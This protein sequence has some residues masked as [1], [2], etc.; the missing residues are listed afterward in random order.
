LGND[1]KELNFGVDGY[2]MDQTYLR[3]LWD[4]R[5]WKPQ[6]VVVGFVPHDLARTMA[7]YPFVS[8]GW[9]GYL[10]KPRFVLENGYLRLL[11]MPFVGPDAV[12]GTRRIHDLP[13]IEFDVGYGTTDWYWH[14]NADPLRCVY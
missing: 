10:I 1:V 6:V 3:Y 2:V 5:P 8:F 9:P 7:I 4:V 11:H 12:L 14:L 13:F